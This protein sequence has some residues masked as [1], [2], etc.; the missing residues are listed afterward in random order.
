MKKPQKLESDQ[1]YKGMPLW[2]QSMIEWVDHQMKACP[3]Q[4]R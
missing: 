3:P 4:G 2:M 1:F